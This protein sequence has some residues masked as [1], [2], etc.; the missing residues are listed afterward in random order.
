MQAIT[1]SIDRIFGW[2][3]GATGQAFKVKQATKQLFLNYKG[4]TGKTSISAAYGYY[5]ASIGKRVLMID[6]DAQAHLTTCF[7]QTSAHHE[8][9]LY[10]VIVRGGRISEIIVDTTLPTLKIIPSTLSLSSME[11]MLFRMPYREFRLRRAI[12]EVER[13]FDFIII[14]AAPNIG[15][16][17]LNAILASDEILI[18]LLADFLSFHGLKILME[19][20]TS[21]QKDFG[22]YLRKIAIFL[23]RYNPDYVI[24]RECHEA[25]HKHYP[26]YSLKT[27]I[28]ESHDIMDATSAGKSVFEL[29]PDSRAARDIKELAREINGF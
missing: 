22:F 28:H 14:D 15:L 9:S 27:V 13:D 2:V 6:L 7:N 25:I 10:S 11:L 18:P 26:D 21:I 16:L 20:L 23:N 3:R 19:T 29:N 24:C 8:K 4:G 5:L 1:G 12:K 17:S